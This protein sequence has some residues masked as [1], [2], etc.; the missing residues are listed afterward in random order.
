MKN[1][2]IPHKRSNSGS[3]HDLASDTR[4]REIKIPATAEYVIILAAYYGGKG[5]ST[6]ATAEAAAKKVKSL[7]KDGTSFEAFEADGTHIEWDGCDFVS[8]NSNLDLA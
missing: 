2:I 4:D 1:I 3:I 5:Y 6:H 7:K 8:G